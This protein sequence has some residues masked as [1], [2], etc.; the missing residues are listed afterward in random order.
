M[1]D[2]AAIFQEWFSVPPSAARVVSRLHAARGVVVYH[3]TLR[4][5]ARQTQNGLN[6]S[7]KK[8]RE[9]MDEGAIANVWSAGFKLSPA[10]IADCDRALADAAQRGRAA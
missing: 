4:V 8:L 6:L 5:D 1:T 9:A 10:G 7:I 3:A 2:R